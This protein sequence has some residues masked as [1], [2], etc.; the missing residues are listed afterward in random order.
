MSYLLQVL[1]WADVMQVSTFCINGEMDLSYFGLHD[2]DLLVTVKGNLNVVVIFKKIVCLR[3]VATFWERNFFLN[4]T[5]PLYTKPY[6]SIKNW[7]SLFGVEK[8]DCLA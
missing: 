4:M 2:L 6:R 3:F 7:F 5:M 1:H 8:P